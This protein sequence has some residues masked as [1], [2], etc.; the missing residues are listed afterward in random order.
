MCSARKPTARVVLCEIRNKR[1]TQRPAPRF[2]QLFPSSQLLRSAHQQRDSP[3]RTWTPNP[4]ARHHQSRLPCLCVALPSLQQLASGTI[5]SRTRLCC[6]FGLAGTSLPLIS[7]C[8]SP[9]NWP[10]HARARC[11]V[12]WTRCGWVKGGVNGGILHLIIVKK[13]QIMQM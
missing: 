11:S 6:I 1:V 4:F 8:L 9:C 5:T 7:L 13:L 12:Q 10:L 3:A 2:I